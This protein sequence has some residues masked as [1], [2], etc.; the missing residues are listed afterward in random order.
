[1][2]SIKAKL[3]LALL[4]SVMLPML[5]VGFLSGR[6]ILLNTKPIYTDAI[7]NEL[8]LVDDYF[9]QFFHDTEDT[10]NYLSEKKSILEGHKSLT[11]YKDNKNITEMSLDQS[12]SEEKLIYDDLKRLVDN[13]HTYKAIEFGTPYGGYIRYPLSD[14]RAGYNPP[15]R[16]W[17]KRA[18]SNPGETE[19]TDAAVSSDGTSIELSIVKAVIKDGQTLGVVSVKVTLDS[20]TDII[21]SI[22]IGDDGYIL[23]V[24][25]ESTVLADPT[26]PENNFKDL[27]DI[28]AYAPLIESEFTNDQIIID[29]KS[30]TAIFRKSEE[31]RFRYIAIIHNKEIMELFDNFIKN[32]LITTTVL[33][34]LFTLLSLF[35]SNSISMPIKIIADILKNIS[36]GQGDL[37]QELKV[38]TKDELSQMA[39]SFN[40]FTETMNSMIL[41]IKNSTIELNKMGEELAND[42]E[43]TSTAITQITANIESTKSQIN[44]QEL[45][46]S[47]TSSAVEE[48]TQNIE[49]LN[50]M[51]DDQ[52]TAVDDSNTSINSMVNNISRVNTNIDNMDTL[53]T[54]LQSSSEAGK[55][56]IKNVFQ[57]AQDISDQ[58]VSLQETNKVIAN[59]ANKTNLLAMNAA[60]EAA[61]AGESGKGFAVVA[62]EIRKLAE[63]SSKQSTDIGNKLKDITNVIDN[64]VSASKAAEEGFSLVAQIIEK[65]AKLET[66]IKESMVTQIDQSNQVASSLEKINGL[67]IGVKQGSEEMKIGNNQILEDVAAL[68]DISKQIL[69]S[70]EEISIGNMD[71]NNSV[72][73]VTEMSKINRETIQKVF[74]SVS[75]FKLKDEI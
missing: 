35:L 11:I 16:G 48:I 28:T 31:L 23:L 19:I 38:L 12:T 32:L 70:I 14:R 43:E 17:Y 41:S 51:V 36:K 37:T 13:H 59:I 39:N 71:I 55:L 20:L 1:M 52:V 58:S 61:H 4:A 74:E 56:K 60:I 75:K 22:K 57:R 50:R 45:R 8:E 68:S 34:A 7:E 6:N 67:T 65:I 2:K 40:D 69:H 73:K 46:V 25:G 53:F 64:V 29:E 18:I 15:D 42:M 49:S 44:T 27:K 3:L 54:D 9:E 47:S 72:L 62:D 10:V 63:T 5:I 30:V 26:H 24:G 33:A 66:E 21:K